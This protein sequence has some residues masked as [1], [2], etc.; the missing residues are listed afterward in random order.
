MTGATLSVTVVVIDS[1]AELTAT[2]SGSSMDMSVTIPS[3]RVTTNGTLTRTSAQPPHSGLTGTY[4]GTFT[5]TILPCHK[6]PA[7][8]FSGTLSGTLLQAGTAIGGFLTATG[9]KNDSCPAGTLVDAPPETLF[10]SGQISGSTIAGFIVDH[11][12][13]LQPFTATISGNTISATAAGDVPGESVTFTITRTSTSAAPSIL[14]FS[15]DPSTID[16]GQTAALSWS[17]F[18]ATSVSIDNGVGSQPVTGNTRVSPTKTT[19]YTLAA[20]G[21]GGTA[22][23]TT[24]VTVNPPVP[25]IVVSTLPK[26]I[27]QAV[28]DS[29]AS[30]RFP[31]ANVGTGPA[32]ITLTQS[33]DFFTISPTSFTLAPG[34]SQTVTIRATAQPPGVYNGSVTVNGNGVPQGGIVVPVRLLVAAPP[35]AAVNAQPATGRVD[36]AAPVGQ[37][38]SSSIPFTNSGTGILQGIALA[39]VPWIIPQPDII[40]INPGETKNVTFTIDRSK[41]PDSSALLGGAFGKISLVFLSSAVEG[42]HR[43]WNDADRQRVSDDRRRGEAGRHIG[44]TAA[45]AGR[46]AGAV[47]RRPRNGQRD[48]RRSFPVEP[49]RIEHLR[50]EAIRNGP[51]SD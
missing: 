24:T 18:N 2:V 1:R 20:T 42:N 51:G 28:G 37:N 36:V 5:A 22:T 23:A 11:K 19:T 31:V 10:V 21:P 40:T 9:D 30:D 44:F 7:V 45:A 46:R 33:G 32:S 26:G 41:R 48:H 14:S 35:T 17:T 43:P 12:G 27:L 15:A 4:S 47:R 3:E 13:N 49:Q 16:P 6:P 39:D 25:R 34:S 29:G 50:H 38:P 8:T